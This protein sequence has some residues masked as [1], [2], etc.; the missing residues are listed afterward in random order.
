MSE[1]TNVELELQ[2]AGREALAENVVGLRLRHPDNA[3]LPEWTPGAHIDLVLDDDLVRQYSLVGPVSDAFEWRI[4]VLIEA[5]GRGGSQHVFENLHPGTPVRARGP[6]NHFE[7]APAEEYR[8]IAGGIG[9]TPLTGMLAEA[10]RAGKPWTLTYGGRTAASMAFAQELRDRYGDRVTL[11]PQDEQG[12][13]DLASLI[14]EP[15]EKTLIYCCGP[16]PLL[17]AVEAAAANWPRDSLRFE[18]FTPA[19]PADSGSDEAFEVELALSDLVLTVPPGK[20]ILD[21]VAEA[22]IDVLSS[23]AEGMCGTCETPLLAGEA[24][25]RD[26]VLTPEEKDENGSMMICVSRSKGARLVLE[27]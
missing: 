16:A 10:D 13:I 11:V 20:S 14:G 27:L 5:D 9:I 26:S 23:C 18:R 19:E 17:E 7:L 3:P 24:D 25:H 15:A 8:F 2:V 6:R 12:L 22:G 1:Q 21:T 4:G